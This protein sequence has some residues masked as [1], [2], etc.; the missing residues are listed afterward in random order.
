MMRTTNAILDIFARFLQ[1]RCG[2]TA[3]EYTLIASIV[4]IGIMVGFG[5]IGTS[6]RELFGAVATEVM[7]ASN[8]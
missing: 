1:S 6:V 8:R 4:S 2:T 7:Q 5:M 3:I